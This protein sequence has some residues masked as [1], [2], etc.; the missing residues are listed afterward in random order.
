MLG[1]TRDEKLAGLRRNENEF[2]VDP[3]GFSLEYTLAAMAPFL[4][5]YKNY[6]RVQTFGI[7]K[8]PKGRVLLLSNHSG[9]LPMDAAMIGLALRTDRRP[10]GAIQKPC[11]RPL[12][13][14]F[15]QL[16][17]R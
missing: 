10:A 12:Y 9:Q 17:H 14:N 5:L 6:H 2:G 16:R 8:V 13:L 11:R 4:W 1:P 3:F 7:E 15:P